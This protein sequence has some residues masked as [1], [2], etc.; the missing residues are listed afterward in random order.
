MKRD[1]ATP[2][3]PT[4]KFS[5]MDTNKDGKVSSAERKAASKA[6]IGSIAN[7]AYKAERAKYP[8]N[9]QVDKV[10]K[11][12]KKSQS[13]L[14]KMAGGTGVPVAKAKAN[15]KDKAL[16]KKAKAKQRNPKPGPYQY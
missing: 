15:A 3:A 7:K 2:L 16:N 14:S 12:K 6:K 13:A 5:P 10:R 4:G 11:A 8:I 9:K 1:L